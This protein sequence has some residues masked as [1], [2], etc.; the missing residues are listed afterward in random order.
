MQKVREQSLDSGTVV[1]LQGGQ[2]SLAG[3][4]DL[5][6]RSSLQSQ[7]GGAEER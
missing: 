6:V 5:L 1:A 4:A 2:P 3:D 7:H